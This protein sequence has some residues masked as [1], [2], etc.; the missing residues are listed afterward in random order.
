MKP[1]PRPLLFISLLLAALL[2]FQAC[3]GS[4]GESARATTS[5][6]VPRTP[7]TAEDAGDQTAPAR[8]HREF[9]L[10]AQELEAVAALAEPQAAAAILAAPERFLELASQ[11]L[12]GP[13]E[14]LWLVDKA[15]PL[16][17]G[18]EPE[19]LVSLEEYADR[20]SLNREGL[21]LR[22]LIMED[23]LAMVD[24]AGEEGIE[25]LIS[26]SYRSYEYQAWL[27]EYW[28]G[29]LGLEEAERSSAR[30]G[31]SEHQLGTTIDFGTI[32]AAFAD[33]AAGRWLQRRSGEFGFSLSYPDGYEE[34]TG[35]KYEPWHFRY[36]GVSATAMQEAYFGG[37][38]QRMLEFWS[39]AREPLE[40]AY[41][42]QPPADATTPDSEN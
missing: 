23:L 14:L 31:T 39:L 1:V 38:Q 40:A 25:L 27:F 33:T 20:L 22:R 30:P 9:T 29:E 41:E 21:S 6:E 32:T 3:S 10:S 8:L 26:S 28:V 19:D 4:S 12:S 7:P 24:A 34:I 35:Y 5:Q 18:Y 17:E 16:P 15:N 2:L 42:P 37:I 36:I 13:P 11:M